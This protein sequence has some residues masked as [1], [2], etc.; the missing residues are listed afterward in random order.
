VK[1]NRVHR[2][3]LLP[4]FGCRGRSRRRTGARRRGGRRRRAHGWCRNGPGGMT[5]A[6]HRDRSNRGTPRRDRADNRDS[7][8]ESFH[9]NGLGRP[10]RRLEF[11][12]RAT[13]A[14]HQDQRRRLS[15]ALW[16]LSGG[17]P[18]RPC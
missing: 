16:N 17:P 2:R 14:T 3:G 11:A 6:V 15:R 4:R 1:L 5:L 8:D 12:K 9:G 7:D 18:P 13:R 10:A